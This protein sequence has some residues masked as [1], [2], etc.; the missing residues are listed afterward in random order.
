MLPIIIQDKFKIKLPNLLEIII[1]L[2][3]F[4]G[5]VLGGIY[6]FYGHLPHWDTILH[7]ISGFICAGIGFALVDLLNKSSKKIKLSPF[8]IVFVAFCFSMTAGVCWEFFEY[9]ADKLFQTDM[10]KDA[11]TKTIS[12]VELDP[13]KSNRSV[14]IRNIDKTIMYDK[15]GKELAVIEGGYLDIG[16]ND[17]MKDLLSNFIGAVVFSILGYFYMGGDEDRHKLANN[18]IPKRVEK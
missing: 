9:G 15:D 1:Y 7:A 13:L 17:T 2:F 12:T 3:I 16:I 6:N 14:V 11:I 10:Q 4:S 5:T 8:Y 18:F